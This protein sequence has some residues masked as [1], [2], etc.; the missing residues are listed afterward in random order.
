MKHM[1]IIQIV[2][3][4]IAIAVALIHVIFPTLKIDSITLTLMTLAALPWLAPL[5]KSIE[6]PGGV[7]LE[8]SEKLE[9]ITQEAEVAGLITDKTIKEKQ[10]EYDFL[11]Y[12][13]SNPRLALAALRMEL[14][15]ALKLL[16]KSNGIVNIKHS[17]TFLMNDLYSKELLSYK[18]RAAL[19]DMVGT[20]NRAVHGEEIDSRTTNW[21]IDIAPQILNSIN[22]KVISN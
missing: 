17:V 13:E 7:K 18:E 21:I 14:E 2:I 1:K 16:A 3:S 12:A 22:K 5:F 10:P 6:L 11:N 4:I 15:N 8:L 9:K 19:A 20:L